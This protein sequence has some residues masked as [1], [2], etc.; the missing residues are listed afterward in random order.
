MSE[1]IERLYRLE[2]VNR[3]FVDGFV[4]GSW[5]QLAGLRMKTN[6]TD[7]DHAAAMA[8]V[9]WNEEKKTKKEK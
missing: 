7:I 6:A 2:D 1:S 5:Q 4:R 8:L 3:A 9:V